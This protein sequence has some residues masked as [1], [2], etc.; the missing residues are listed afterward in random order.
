MADSVG[1]QT[2]AY[3][4]TGGQTP[5]AAGGTV[6]RLQVCVRALIASHV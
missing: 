2:P 4:G 6:P 1:G 3:A 5:S